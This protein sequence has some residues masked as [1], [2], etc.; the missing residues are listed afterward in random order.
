MQPKGFVDFCRGSSGVG[1]V[2][3][4]VGQLPDPTRPRGVLGK[5]PA[6]AP[7]DVQPE[8]PIIMLFREVFEPPC[9]CIGGGFSWTRQ[10]KKHTRLD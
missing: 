10:T 4:D 7:L 3:I 9:D 1:P 2:I 6:G 5:A 8:R